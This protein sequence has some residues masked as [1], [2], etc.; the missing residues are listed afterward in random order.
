MKTKGLKKGIALFL[1]AVMTLGLCIIP[2]PAVQ[3]EENMQDSGITIT[4]TTDK[5]EVKRGDIIT[6]TA[7]LKGIP[8]DSGIYSTVF[9]AVYNSSVVEPVKMEIIT[10]ISRLVTLYQIT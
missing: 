7:S 9:K 3:A 5:K 2:V 6:L 10:G 8:A 1:A 4:I